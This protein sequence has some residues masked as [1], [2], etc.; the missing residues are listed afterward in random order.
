EPLRTHRRVPSR[1]LR[2]VRRRFLCRDRACRGPGPGRHC[3]RA[4]RRVLARDPAAPEAHH[5][6]DRSCL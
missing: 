4:R 5:R 1:L 2:V 3:G 6:S